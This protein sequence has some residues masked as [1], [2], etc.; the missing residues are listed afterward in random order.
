MPEFYHVDRK[1][2]LV[3]G[4]ELGLEPLPTDQIL[5]TFAGFPEYYREKADELF[6]KQFPD[7]VTPHGR[8]YLTGVESEQ[9][10]TNAIHEQHVEFVRQAYYPEKPSRF[11]STF[12]C[13]TVDEAEKFAKEF[14]DNDG[15][16]IIW[17]VEGE[18]SHEGDLGFVTRWGKLYLPSLTLATLYWESEEAKASESIWEAYSDHPLL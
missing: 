15:K 16:A 17:R 13:K 18:V 11:E 7:G 8:R 10:I 3:P 4:I 14:G 5:S 1:H 2:T 9:Q 12:A 6:E